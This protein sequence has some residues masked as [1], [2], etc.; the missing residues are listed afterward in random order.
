MR[1]IEKDTR[2]LELS[3]CRVVLQQYMGRK[4]ED[5]DHEW[6]TWCLHR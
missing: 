2:D 5:A 3:S 6:A 1:A 4:D